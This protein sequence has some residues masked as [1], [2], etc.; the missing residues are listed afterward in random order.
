MTYFKESHYALRGCEDE[1]RLGQVQLSHSSRSRGSLAFLGVLSYSQ[2][3]RTSFFPSFCSSFQISYF[4]PGLLFLSLPLFSFRSCKLM[5]FGSCAG[6]H[7]VRERFLLDFLEAFSSEMTSDQPNALSSLMSLRLSSLL[8]Y[9]CCSQRLLLNPINNNNNN[10]SSVFSRRVTENC[11][12]KIDV[13]AKGDTLR[14]TRNYNH[15]EEVIII[16]YRV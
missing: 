5:H 11:L 6:A 8:K 9:L 13:T 3:F 14:R 4:F 2:A 7:F 16:I 1:S 15:V 10:F 12:C